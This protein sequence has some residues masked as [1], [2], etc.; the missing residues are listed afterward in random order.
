MKRKL[1]D[2]SEQEE[3]NSLINTTPRKRRT[4]DLQC[5][6]K[7]RNNTD[8][9]KTPSRKL[10]AANN[11]SK[12]QPTPVVNGP[13]Q[14]SLTP[15]GKSRSL[16]ATPS[17][18]TGKKP[19]NASPPIVRNADRSARRKSARVLL[20]PND[21]DDWDGA[22]QLAQEIWDAEDEETGADN[23]EKGTKKGKKSQVN[24]TENPEAS[25]KRRAGRP[26]GAKNR[27]SPTPEGDL[28]PH[29]RY[30][31]Q[32]RPG[33]VQTSDNT[34][35]KLSLLTH[36]EYFEQL[37]KFEDPH[38][39]EK[40]FL[41]ELHERSFPQWEFELSEGFNI[42]L[43]GYGSKR[44]LVNRFA[45]FLSQRHSDPPTIVIVNGYMSSTTIRSILATIIGAILGPDTP[46][47]LGT[48]P[49]E[50]LELLQSILDTKPPPHPIMV[51]IN[52]I[53]ASALRRAAHQSILARLASIPLINVLATADTPNFPILWDVSH[54]DQF[55]FVFHDC[56]TFIPYGVELNVVDVVNSL[57]GHQVRR[58]G[59]KDGVNFVLK[60]LPENTRKLYRLLVTEILT[61][62][63]E[64]H[65]S[66]DEDAGAG[67]NQDR[68]GNE[69]EE[70]AIEWR[71]LFHKAA[72]EFISS[73]EMMFRTQLKEFYDHQMI[74]SRTD[75]SGAEL[76]GIP[77]SR[78]EMEG[79]LEDLVID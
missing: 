56:T 75:A 36:E 33:P 3:D 16:F 21:D 20:D 22:V 45:E 5:S 28:P 49:S 78:E 65:L 6:S 74:V 73:S 8:L 7:S 67:G 25:P 51:F 70:V 47:K 39:E 52:S 10:R 29:E 19:T 17:K 64:Q 60:S 44:R 31:F 69:G 76:L 15:K 54:R 9:P 32:N 57:L 13:I 30:F 1:P 72:E 68:G 71:T 2:T 37:G 63:G 23:G 38:R 34:L 46:S 59:G 24:G 66:D 27:R 35:A 48:Q 42:C 43:Y 61:L 41:L 40:E 58:I 4:A 11:K 50:V 79:V 26:K 62:L 53:D 14:D 77:L 12:I 55:N 18:A